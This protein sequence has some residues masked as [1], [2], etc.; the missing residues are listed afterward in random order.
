[1]IAVRTSQKRAESIL[2]LCIIAGSACALWQSIDEIRLPYQID[3]GEGLM[4]EGA[5]RL[6]HGQPLYGDPRC[7]PH[8]LHVYGPV[9]YFLTSLPVRM[10]GIDYRPA[11]ALTLLCALLSALA[12]A[13]LLRHWTGSWSIGLIFGFSFLLVPTV[14]TWLYLIRADFLALSLSLIGLV[15]YVLRPRLWWLSIFFFMLAIYAK[16]TF[17]AAPLAVGTHLLVEKQWR[18][19]SVFCA[20]CLGLGILSFLL[21]QHASGNWFAFHM[22]HTHADRYSMLQFALLGLV[23]VLSAPV[24]IGLAVSSVWSASRSREFSLGLLFLACALMISLTAG[25]LGST[26]NHFLEFLAAC[27]L[28]AG[29]GFDR[30]KRNQSRLQL[31]LALVLGATLLVPA[32]LQSRSN[33]RPDAELSGCSDAY[34]YVAN[35]AG[36]N[37]LAENLGSVMLA[38]K[39]V[40]LTDP[41][42]YAQLV[43]NKAWP[44]TTLVDL[45]RSRYFDLVVLGEN[46]AGEQDLWPD[47]VLQAIRLNYQS[48]REFHC[49]HARVMLRP[50]SD[51]TPRDV[52]A[53]DKA[54]E[55]SCQSQ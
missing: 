3:Y 8:Q 25:N 30:L 12:I 24:L 9:A 4:L 32:V 11:R 26:T 52:R 43:K 14:R 1:M 20:S 37:V 51:D 31:G 50:K 5:A 42:V 16:Y 19:A 10:F 6:V 21:L 17:M 53:A 33:L 38:N 22:F 2:A 28:C 35:H 7:F 39:T 54:I 29:L 23:V 47:S 46:P 34:R 44:D 13:Y 40:P 18:R 15:I 45:V 49:P 36:Q 55:H 48:D 27:S 41:F